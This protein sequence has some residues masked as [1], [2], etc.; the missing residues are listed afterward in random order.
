MLKIKV[1]FDEWNFYARLCA[2]SS[3]CTKKWFFFLDTSRFYHAARFLMEMC[4]NDWIYLTISTPFKWV[5]WVKMVDFSTNQNATNSRKMYFICVFE[6]SELRAPRKNNFVAKIYFLPE[7]RKKK[8]I[9]SKIK[10]QDWNI[11]HVNLV[12]KKWQI[13][14]Y[15]SLNVELSLKMNFLYKFCI[16]NCKI[17]KYINL[18]MFLPH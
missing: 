8:T 15:I 12:T 18:Q 17:A 3:L 7:K 4:S 1:I 6:K 10:S 11:R 16:Q 2:I 13:Q 5:K 9:K 14:T